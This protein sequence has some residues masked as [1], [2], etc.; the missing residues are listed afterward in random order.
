MLRRA[1]PV[2][3]SEAAD[4]AAASGICRGHPVAAAIAACWLRAD[5]AAAYRLDVAVN[6]AG[7]DASTAIPTIGELPDLV[8]GEPEP[9]GGGVGLGVAD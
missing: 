4:P 7:Y 1:A 2:L 8:G 3:I 9:R 5:Q 6:S